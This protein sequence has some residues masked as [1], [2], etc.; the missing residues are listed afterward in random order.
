MKQLLII[1]DRNR[2]DND[3]SLA[4]QY[5]AGYEYNDFYHPGV[6]DDEGL[7]DE[8]IKGYA[9]AH[10]PEFCTMHGAFYDVIPF[11]PDERIREISLKR[12]EQ[13]IAVAQRIG[14]GAVIFHTNYNPFL[15]SEAYVKDW[16]AKNEVI[17]AEILEKHSDINIYLENMFD[18]TPD[19]MEALSE[20]LCRYDNYGVCL[21]YAHAA[22]SKVAPKEW[23]KRLGKYVKHIHIND[24]DLV[25]DLHLA[26]GDGQIDRQTFYDAYDKYM[27][28]ASV[29]VE[30]SSYENKK[31]S[32]EVLKKEGFI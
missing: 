2:I 9:N 20:R 18:T 13:S 23:A 4:K 6:L 5:S 25:S 7:L 31:R 22:L 17:W 24:N 19:M 16:L 11:S 28:K 27:S 3:I 29:L 26:W 15:N 1:P 10:R 12:I 14:A 8:I 30:T 32:F 21:D